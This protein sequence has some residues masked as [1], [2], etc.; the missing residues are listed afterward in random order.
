MMNSR[1][2]AEFA[3]FAAICLIVAA[4]CVWSALADAWETPSDFNQGPVLT[5]HRQATKPL[6]HGPLL[7]G[8]ESPLHYRCELGRDGTTV[9]L[10]PLEGREDAHFVFSCVNCRCGGEK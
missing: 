8:T 10:I 1:Q 2:R 6:Y 5:V 3:I 4:V 7:T 9:T